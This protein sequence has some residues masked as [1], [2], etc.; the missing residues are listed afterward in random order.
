MFKLSSSGVLILAVLLLPLGI[1]AQ[2]M[3]ARP[4]ACDSSSFGPSKVA[5]CKIRLARDSSAAPRIAL[6]DE[7]L[8]AGNWQGAAAEYRAAARADSGAGTPFETIWLNS[9]REM[10]FVGPSKS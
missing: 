8:R 2:A 4:V 1:S 10:N 3:L 5:A 6:A 7:Y 9:F